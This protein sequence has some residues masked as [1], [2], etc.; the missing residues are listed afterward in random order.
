MT[1]L[2]SL[3]FGIAFTAHASM[4][5]DYNSVH[6]YVECTKENGA[7]INV[8]HNSVDETTLFVGYRH[9]FNEDWSAD[10][11]LATGYVEDYPVPMGRISYKNFFISPGIE[12]YDNEYNFGTVI[13]IEFK[14][15]K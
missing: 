12:Y 8:Y 5:G 14:F 1:S 4:V 15:G 3:A 11:G 13:G 2:C 6:P 10:I 9:R 7:M